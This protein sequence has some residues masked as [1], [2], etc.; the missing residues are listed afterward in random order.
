MYVSK[1][2]RSKVAHLI[3]T[4]PNAGTC[5]EGYTYIRTYMPLF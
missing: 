1:E 2:P 4:M 3:L 5:V